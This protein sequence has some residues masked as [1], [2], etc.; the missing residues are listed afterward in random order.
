[1]NRKAVA[2][3]FQDDVYDISVTGRH[4]LVTDTMKEYVIEK[5]S[6]IGR[7]NTRIIDV[8]V[9]MDIQKLDHRIDI[10]MKTDHIVI[11]STAT[12]ENMYTSIDKAIDKLENQLRRYKSRITDH[13]LKAT[14]GIDMNVYILEAPRDE[15]LLEVNDEI[16][17]EN[18]AQLIDGYRPHK[19]ISRETRHLK[20][21]NNDEAIMKM[22]LSG[23]M[24]M[25]FRAED[26]RKLKVIYRR[27][28][29]NFGII[30]P[31]K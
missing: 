26:D 10:T 30:E 25:I 22:E 4:V 19:I 23:D 17:S 16:D 13:H 7:F 14:P 11:K 31:E 15:Q 12:S 27:S 20:T 24:F 1:M 9:V 5:I 2:E 18:R 3:K 29:G 6:K 28:D 8:N 21:L